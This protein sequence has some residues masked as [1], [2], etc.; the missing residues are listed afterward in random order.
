M[1]LLAM[2]LDYRTIM[3]RLQEEG[4]E[5][6][7]RTY[8][9]DRKALKRQ[10]AEWLE[11]FAKGDGMLMF[12]R[13]SLEVLY[14]VQR[15]LLHIALN[16]E[17]SPH[18]RNEANGKIMECQALILNIMFYGPAVLAASKGRFPEQPREALALEAKP[19]LPASKNDT[20]AQ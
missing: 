12:Y 8:F 5:A 10:S 18:E 3:K 13:E 4:F 7:R 14:G 16:P 20:V 9:N 15:R 11:D 6:S 2:R 17:V 1:E 19:T